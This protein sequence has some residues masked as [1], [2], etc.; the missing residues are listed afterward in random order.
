MGE[1]KKTPWGMF[2][3][4]LLIAEV[5]GVFAGRT[6]KNNQG[7]MTIVICGGIFIVWIMFIAY[8]TTYNRNFH[9]DQEYGTA[10]W[11]NVKKIVN[12]LQD[13]DPKKNKIMS[14][15]V[16]ISRTALP[17]SNML[18]IGSPGTGKSAFV[19][20]KNLLLCANS[21]VILDIKGELLSK[22]GNYMKKQGM[23][24]KVLNLK[25]DTIQTSNQYNPF[26]YLKYESEI[27][28]LVSNIMES[29]TPPDAN[30]NDPFWDDGCMLYLQ[31]LFYY[32]WMEKDPE[33]QNM[34]AVLDLV[35]A[36]SR[37]VYRYNGYGDNT[38]PE[39]ITYEEYVRTHPDGYEEDDSQTEL[40]MMMDNLL[41]TG[42]HKE[43]GANHPAFRDYYKLKGG[44]PETVRSIILMIN[45]KLKFFENPEIRRIFEDDEMDLEY[46]GTGY[47]YD[48]KT[49][50]ALFMVLPEN[51]SSYNFMANMLYQQIFDVSMRISDVRYKNNP[52]PIGIDLWMDEVANGVRP[53]NLQNLITTLRGRNIAANLFLQ[54][55]AQLKALF[56]GDS[57]DII[58]DSCSAMVFL[59]AGRGALST[60]EYIS[61]LLGTATIDKKSDSQ[62]PMGNNAHA[63]FSFDK[64][65]R[66]LMMPE[67]V[68]RMS[69]NKCLVFLAGEQPMMDDK[70]KPF[71]DAD[72]KEAM[73]L[74][75][76]EH[77][78]H[79]IK[80]PDGTYIMPH[81]KAKKHMSM[82]DADS[83]AAK[84]FM[85]DAKNN[86]KIRIFDLRDEKISERT[87]RK[88]KKQDEFSEDAWLLEL[89][90]WNT[91]E[92]DLKEQLQKKV[93]EKQQELGTAIYTKEE[94]E[95]LLEHMD[96]IDLLLVYGKDLTEAQRREVTLGI[97]HGLSD[98][99]IK[100]YFFEP[101]EI[102]RQIRELEEAV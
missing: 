10:D 66:P 26:R 83:F 48:H 94:Q 12:R 33:E 90:L 61:K 5:I 81:K 30:K 74:G 57:W 64:V 31:S 97:D 3:A 42:R 101:A 67:E 63:N 55:V 85:E 65:G 1:K 92:A 80:Q 96:I 56:K 62:Q 23:I 43:L 72:Y 13:K 52:L 40:G 39:Y 14:R 11:G 37:K 25:S 98:E 88:Q 59:G 50:T 99:Q 76:Y 6:W 51:D 58:M 71:N 8:Y 82:Y 68:G 47:E 32:V 54:S 17:N 34:N 19:L 91:E 100:G 29:V 22:Y 84:E 78:V 16:I 89:D 24:I 75:P 86:P 7:N 79:A 9:L 2:L 15:H 20:T 70:Y 4:L 44:A 36:E 27:P 102:M 35:N 18:V 38:I 41:V 28:K 93:I 53:H 60:H 46:L 77:Y 69:T 95:A 45:A 87:N 21:M 49:K 73:S